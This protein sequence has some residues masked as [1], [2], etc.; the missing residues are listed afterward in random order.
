MLITATLPAELFFVDANPAPVFNTL[1]RAWEWDLGNRSAKSGP[2]IIVLTTTVAPTATVF[3]TLSSM[4]RIGAISPELETASNVAAV[5]IFV[6]R[7]IYLPLIVRA[8]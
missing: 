8:Y 5:T 4:M 1:L 7:R 6:G 3:S 2:F